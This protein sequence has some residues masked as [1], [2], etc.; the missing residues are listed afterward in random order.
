MQTSNLWSHLQEHFEKDIKKTHLRDLLNDPK[1]NEHLKIELDNIIYDF[2]HEK[3]NDKTLTLLDD[4]VKNSHIWKK[5][6]AMFSGVYKNYE[7]YL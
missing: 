4:L 7:P 1:R 6:E 3:L 5:I 2:T